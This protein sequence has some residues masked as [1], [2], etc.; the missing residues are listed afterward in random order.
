MALLDSEKH[1]NA[2]RP[3]SLSQA[4]VPHD[5]L[6][7]LPQLH[8]EAARNARLGGFLSRSV[9]AAGLLMLAG[10]A[11]LLAGGGTL[12]SDFVWSLLVLAGI[13]A[14][15]VNHLRGQATP[16][17]RVTLDTAAGDLRAVLLYTGFA[18]GAGAFLALPATPGAALALA[19]AA[20]PALLMTVLLKDEGG[21]AAFAAP[22]FGLTAAAAL[23]KHWPGGQVIACELVAVCA[24]IML[25]SHRSNARLQP[26]A[27]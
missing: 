3:D 12:E 17:S 19:F 8:A 18:W 7:R 15:I 6:A 25:F 2:P 11:S 9:H 24:V 4:P 22:C 27:A 23:V 1:S 5:Y 13:A 21:I 14:M 16:L 10:A 20:G 26:G